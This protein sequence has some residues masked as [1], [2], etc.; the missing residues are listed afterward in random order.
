MKAEGMK[1]GVSDLFFSF[2]CNGMHGLW[3]EMKAPKTATSKA[4]KPTQAQLDWLHRKASQGY[5]AELCYGWEAARSA[6]LA[7]I[8][9][10]Q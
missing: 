5:A 8:G 7:Y 1:A 2:P 4:G 9:N 10:P 3:I 6:I